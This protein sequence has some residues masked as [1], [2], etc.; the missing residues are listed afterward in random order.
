MSLEGAALSKIS[1][2]TPDIWLS[3]DAVPDAGRGGDD[4]GLAESFAQRR[5]CDAHGVGEGVGIL[6][7]R[8]FQQLLGADDAAF[9]GDENFEDRELLADE[10][11]VAAVAVDLAAE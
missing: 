7:P 11:D 9:D 5:H 10:R 6:I 4:R 1:A 8:T 3:V 2:L